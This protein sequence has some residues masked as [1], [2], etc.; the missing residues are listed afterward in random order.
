MCFAHGA[1]PCRCRTH[2][3]LGAQGSM[4]VH[5]TSSSSVQLGA[6]CC[7]YL[8]IAHCN[9]PWF[10]WKNLGS[11]TTIQSFAKRDRSCSNSHGSQWW[12]HFGELRNILKIDA[13]NSPT[14]GHFDSLHMIA[15]S[16]MQC[17]LWFSNKKSKSTKTI[18]TI[19]KRDG[20][21][22]EKQSIQDH[23]RFYL[24]HWTI[25]VLSQNMIEQFP[26]I[27]S[28]THAQPMRCFRH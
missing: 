20:L 3:F 24:E 23:W 7:R 1:S 8:S 15:E 25:H 16:S 10:E 22:C 2:L 27:D 21:S 19:A 18:K 14:V 26:I 13:W 28:N 5:R 9:A 11:T 4:A 12:Q 17:W 6:E